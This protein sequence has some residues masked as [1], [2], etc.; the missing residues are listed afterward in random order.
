MRAT[1]AEDPVSVP[2][3]PVP[4]NLIPSSGLRV[5]HMHVVHTHTFMSTHTCLKIK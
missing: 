1:L 3:I 4:G 5:T 2:V